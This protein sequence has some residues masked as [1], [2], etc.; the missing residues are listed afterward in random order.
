MLGDVEFDQSTDG[1]ERIEVI[2]KQPA[3]FRDAK[4]GFDH[5]IGRG[6]VGLCQNS[7]QSDRSATDG[8]TNGAARA[9]IVPAPA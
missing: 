7:L 1:A 4:E 8:V 3:V 6:N 9:M 2:Q 5:R